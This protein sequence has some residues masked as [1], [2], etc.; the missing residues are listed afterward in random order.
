M[1][2]GVVL[3]LLDPFCENHTGENLMKNLKTRA[4]GAT[5]LLALGVSS[6]HAAL[7]V[8]ATDAISAISTGVTDVEAAVWPVIGAAIVAGV[9]IKLV[10]RFSNKV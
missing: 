1:G 4:A 6:A 2:D 5:G 10:K 7:P 8:P 9:V 3:W